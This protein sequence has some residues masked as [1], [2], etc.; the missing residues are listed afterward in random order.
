MLKR[1][2]LLS[3][4]V[5]LRTIVTHP[6]NRNLTPEFKPLTE[7]NTVMFVCSKGLWGKEAA[8]DFTYF[9]LRAWDRSDN[10][11][12]GNH[13]LNAT[14]MDSQPAFSR[15]VAECVA[16]RLGCDNVAGSELERDKCGQCTRVKRLKDRC[17]GCDGRAYSNMRKGNA[18]VL[19]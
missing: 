4:T 5:L 12:S 13:Q 16:L 19:S 11:T 10:R 6:E 7:L 14:F 18:S 8:R 15:H 2:S 1:Q 9:K 17:V 3:L